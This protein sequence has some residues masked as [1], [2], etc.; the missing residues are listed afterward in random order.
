ME[1]LV[2][3]VQDEELVCGIAIIAGGQR[4]EWSVSHYLEELEDAILEVI[5]HPIP[6]SQRS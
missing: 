1:A 6:A 4:I 2:K 5:S 3:F